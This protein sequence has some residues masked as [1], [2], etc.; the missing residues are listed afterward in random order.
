[1]KFTKKNLLEEFS[2][3]FK[4]IFSDFFCEI[5]GAVYRRLLKDFRDLVLK[6]Q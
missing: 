1:M 5:I 6:N 4:G 2:Q 3:N